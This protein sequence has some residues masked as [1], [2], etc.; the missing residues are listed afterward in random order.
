ML[1]AYVIPV[2]RYVSNLI[3]IQYVEKAY[4]F[5]NMAD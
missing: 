3:Y 2:I 5:F 4:D 1:L